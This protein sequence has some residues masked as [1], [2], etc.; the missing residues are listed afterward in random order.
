MSREAG[1]TQ[2]KLEPKWTTMAEA[3]TTEETQPLPE[4]PSETQEGREI[5]LLL[6]SSHPQSSESASHWLSP[7]TSQLTR[8]HAGVTHSPDVGSALG[9]G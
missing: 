3:G 5:L 4:N 7:A 8:E 1:A 2:R 6:P 9:E